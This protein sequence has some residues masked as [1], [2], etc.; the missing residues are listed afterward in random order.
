MPTVYLATPKNATP[1]IDEKLKY[2]I[3]GENNKIKILNKKQYN[4]D[5]PCILALMIDASNTKFLKKEIKN[6][7]ENL[8][9]HSPAKFLELLEDKFDIQEQQERKLDGSQD[10]ENS[11]LA[12]TP[13]STVDEEHKQLIEAISSSPQSILKPR[14]NSIRYGKFENGDLRKTLSLYDP[15]NGGSIEI[16]QAISSSL[17]SSNNSIHNQDSFEN[18]KRAQLIDGAQKIRSFFTE[19]EKNNNLA[20][21]ER[22]GLNIKESYLNGNEKSKIL[23]NITKLAAQIRDSSDNIGNTSSNEQIQSLKQNVSELDKIINN[24]QNLDALSRYRGFSPFKCFATLWGGGKVKSIEYV[25]QLRDQ[26]NT[27]T[28]EIAPIRP[29]V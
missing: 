14:P 6:H 23:L 8:N 3:I 27:L 26:L 28:Q 9:H 1:I 29:A 19:K 21:I 17:S 20:K 7:I 4:P 25:E 12:T 15:V 2:V 13:K 5:S 22:H 24:K 10:Q 16:Q 18:L 11:L